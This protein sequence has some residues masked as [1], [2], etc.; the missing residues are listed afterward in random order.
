MGIDYNIVW[1]IIQKDITSLA[2]DIKN[3]VGKL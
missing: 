3:I 1:T 2:V